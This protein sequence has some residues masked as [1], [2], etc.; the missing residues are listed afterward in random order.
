[1]N[2]LVFANCQSKVTILILCFVLTQNKLKREEAFS[3]LN[4]AKINQEWRTILRN[5]K[6]AELRT[7]VKNLQKYFEDAFQR[8]NQTID[9]LLFE[10]DE[11]EE[12]YAMMLQSHLK[13]IDK[14]IGNASYTLKSR[15]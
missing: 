11:T 1:M 15:M 5:I 14:L 8:K 7:E 13:A 3:R 12:M 4:M 6:C 2:R 9:R 10:L